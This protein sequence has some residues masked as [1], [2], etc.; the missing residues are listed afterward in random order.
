MSA[1]QYSL[2]VRWITYKE[3]EIFSELTDAKAAVL[4]LKT[5]PFQRRWVEELQ[6]IQLKMEVAGTSRIEGADF[7]A[8]ELEVAIKA[9]TAEQLQTRSQKQANAAVRTYKWIAQI[10]DKV[11]IDE[12]LICTVHKLIVTDCDEDHCPP[13][14]IRWED[15]NVTFGSPKHRG[16]IGGK[17]CEKAFKKLADGIQGEFRDH[18][19]LI[20]ALALHYHFGAIHPFLDG[21]GRTARALEALV[22]QRAGLKDSLFIAMSNYYYDEKR[23]YLEALAEVRAN[24]NDLT[25]FLKFGLR[26]IALQAG[27]LGLMIREEVSRQIFRNLMHELFTRL[28]S[29]RKRVIVRRQLALLE[30]LL[31]EGKIEFN[32]L[33]ES[34]R[35]DYSSRKNP[36]NAIIRDLNRLQALGAVRIDQSI[37]DKKT[38]IFYIT[39]RLDWP[40]RITETEVFTKLATLPKA[41]T[42]GFL[43]ADE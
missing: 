28:E 4:V 38:P 39:V 3:T 25:P 2:P 12:K 8:N 29:T 21:N 34:V 41:K 22:L 13:G 27:R 10:P 42:Y 26:G 15:Q 7:A 40:S 9:E 35:K 17:D 37:P 31:E 5:I 14:R 19:L 20:Q 43:S 6:K 1:I 18:D 24:G 11:P 23:A 30:K 32:E 16:A 33:V 36:M